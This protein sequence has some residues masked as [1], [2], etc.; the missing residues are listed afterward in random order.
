M[1]TNFHKKKK[2]SWEEFNLQ[3]ICQYDLNAIL[4]INKAHF[5]I[6]TEKKKHLIKKNSI[7]NKFID[8]LYNIP[9]LYVVPLKSLMLDHHSCCG[10][11]YIYCHKEEK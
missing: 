5:R 10:I 4:F 9:I 8:E 1:D 6:Y 11:K 7:F 2:S 3:Q